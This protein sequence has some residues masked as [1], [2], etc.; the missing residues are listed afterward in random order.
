M[1]T[2]KKIEKPWGYELIWA[3]TDQY[4]GKILHVNKGQKLSLQFHNI[5]DETIHLL[6]GRLRFE[7]EEN[8]VMVIRTL[9]PGDSYHIKPKCKH[10]MDAEEICEILEAS[11]PFLDDVVRLQDAY[12]RVQPASNG[13]KQH[14]S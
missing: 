10:R 5:K 2:P 9:T 6:A 11:T 14:S 1:F 12:G 3:Q 8:G 4:I 7:I 13:K